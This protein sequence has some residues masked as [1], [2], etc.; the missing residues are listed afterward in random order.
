M[1]STIHSFAQGS[2]GVEYN[3]GLIALCDRATKGL[4]LYLFLVRTQNLTQT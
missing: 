3:S 4:K 2:R 1:T